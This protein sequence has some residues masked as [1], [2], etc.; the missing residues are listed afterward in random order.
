MAD[1]TVI[2]TVVDEN[3]AK[4]ASI[5]D[6]FLE[7]FR[8]GEGTERVLNHLLIIAEDIQAFQYCNSKHPHCFQLKNF[9]KIQS[10]TP[11]NLMLCPS[12]VILLTQI[13]ELGFHVA[14]TVSLYVFLFFS[15]NWDHFSF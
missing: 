4:P 2:M 5:L 7:S 14:F 1:R 12:R 15:E 8:I 6:L 3:W 10:R 9:P 11:R 13:V